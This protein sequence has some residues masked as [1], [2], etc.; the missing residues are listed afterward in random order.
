MAL[1]ALA[2]SCVAGP[3]VETITT[4][5]TNVY[6]GVNSIETLGPLTFEYT[7]EPNWNCGL[8]PHG[9]V[10]YQLVSF[11]LAGFQYVDAQF[12]PNP[13]TW[14]GVDVEGTAPDGT[15]LAW[16]EG[17]PSGSFFT[18]GRYTTKSLTGETAVLTVG[19]V[20]E[21]SSVALFALAMLGL[22]SAICGRQTRVH[23]ERA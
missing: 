8:C 23:H 22:L 6:D 4:T 16:G 21:P 9:A 3:L 19:I 1:A 15:I 18:P 2:G 13:I 17:F 20:P 11:N 12:Y 10:Y 7:L 14:D 5:S